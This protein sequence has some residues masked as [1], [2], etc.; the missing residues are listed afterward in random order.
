LSTVTVSHNQSLRHLP[1]SVSKN[2]AQTFLLFIS[3]RKSD[4]VLGV[5]CV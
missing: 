1:T 3:N 4:I 5:G 2:Q